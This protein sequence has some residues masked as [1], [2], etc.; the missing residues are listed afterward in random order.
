[1]PFLARIGGEIL[2]QGAG[3]PCEYLTGA[4]DHAYGM[5]VKSEQQ[6][7]GVLPTCGHAL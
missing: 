2:L 4:Y 3:R 6:E 5:P 7:P 1:M